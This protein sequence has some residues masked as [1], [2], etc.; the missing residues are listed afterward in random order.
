MVKVVPGVPVAGASTGFTGC[1]RPP[2]YTR[3]YANRFAEA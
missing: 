1:L 3:I 2:G